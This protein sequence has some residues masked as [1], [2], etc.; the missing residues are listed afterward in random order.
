MNKVDWKKGPHWNGIAM[1]GTRVNNT[2]PG[3]LATAGYILNE[4]EIENPPDPNDKILRSLFDTYNNSIEEAKKYN[5]HSHPNLK[6]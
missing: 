2:D 3:I 5:S 4:G 1:V 6:I